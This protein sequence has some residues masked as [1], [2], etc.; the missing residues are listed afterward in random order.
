MYKFFSFQIKQNGSDLNDYIKEANDKIAEWSS[1]C[2]QTISLGTLEEFVEIELQEVQRRYDQF[3]NLIDET[4]RNLKIKLKVT[5]DKEVK[6]K[7][8]VMV[9][10]SVILHGWIDLPKGHTPRVSTPY[11]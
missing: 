2:D 3:G 6:Y 4:I 5:K 8:G 7:N 11:V 1:G 10:L 9:V